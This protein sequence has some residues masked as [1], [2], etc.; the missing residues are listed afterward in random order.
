MQDW[1]QENAKCAKDGGVSLRR[2]ESHRRSRHAPD[3]ISCGH[4]GRE[5]A[6]PTFTRGGSRRRPGGDSF[7]TMKPKPRNVFLESARGRDCMARMKRA[8]LSA[9]YAWLTGVAVIFTYFYF[10]EKEARTKAYT[11]GQL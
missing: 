8:F 9:L 11:P 3:S 10:I 1:P 7:T 5:S 4:G 2:N 6:R